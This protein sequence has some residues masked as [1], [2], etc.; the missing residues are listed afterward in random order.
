MRGW[1]LGWLCAATFVVGCG[2][3]AKEPVTE[4]STCGTEGPVQLLEAGTLVP[5]S[6]RLAGD[7]LLLT[8]LPPQDEEMEP[9]DFGVDF[10]TWSVGTCGESPT[11]IAAGLDVFPIGDTLVACDWGDHGLYNDILRI[12]PSGQ[13]DPVVLFEDV[14]CALLVTDQGW[15]ARSSQT[16]EL[17]HRSEPSQDDSTTELLATGVNAIEGLLPPFGSYSDPIPEVSG[18]A[19]AVVDA[20]N[21]LR[22]YDLSDGSSS[23]VATQA[24]WGWSTPDGATLWW[25]ERSADDDG[26]LDTAPVH[27]R[28]L[29]T[30]TDVVVYDGTA[31]RE[32]E[33]PYGL[34]QLRGAQS[35]S[36]LDLRDG[37][38][39]ALPA[40][41]QSIGARPNAPKILWGERD[42]WNGDDSYAW[43]EEEQRAVALPHV[44]AG[45]PR[46]WGPHGLDAMQGEDCERQRGDLWSHPYDGSA[47][48]IVAEDV[49]GWHFLHAWGRVVWSD[50]ERTVD[51]RYRI[52][53]LFVTDDDGGRLRLDDHAKLLP[54]PWK[55]LDGDVVYAVVDGDRSGVWRT[56]TR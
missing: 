3:S 42:L 24:A 49:A 36:L 2:P 21:E 7:R 53:D 10:D 35:N 4:F 32:R 13:A 55:D 28:D 12:D 5:G 56:A 46:E 27:R 8:L 22:V 41:L 18:S 15:L 30:G 52:G 6:A 34:V 25:R 39:H 17:W 48:S 11:Q 47:P 51:G 54:W 31:P 37:T 20:N 38:I 23:V 1:V 16:R 14:D 19:I 29:Q 33:W 40:G 26:D 43:S 44:P 50:G 9:S 45:C